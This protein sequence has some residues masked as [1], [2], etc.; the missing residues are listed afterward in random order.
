MGP[1]SRRSAPATR[2]CCWAWAPTARRCSRSR[3]VMG[4]AGHVRNCP[5]CGATHHPRTDPVVIMLVHDPDRDR[6]LLGR[7]ARWPVGRYSTL[8]GFVEPGESLEEAVVREIG[9]E[10][11]VR[12][13][14]VRY[15]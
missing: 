9:E 12:V 6:V 8:A 13:S 3:P 2:P 4:E 1:R 5:N 15:R 7:Q 14:D 11:G 10:A